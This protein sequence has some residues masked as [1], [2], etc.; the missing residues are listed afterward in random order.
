MELFKSPAGLMATVFYRQSSSEIIS[1]SNSS[2]EKDVEAQTSANVSPERKSI[3][4]AK[5]EHA[6]SGDSEGRSL[7]WRDLHLTVVVGGEEK[8][9]LNH[10][11]GYIAPNSMTALMGVSGAG[12]VRL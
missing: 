3:S 5:E 10:L 11:D 7:A 4:S 9:L 1:S 12:K 8:V 6:S 2:Q